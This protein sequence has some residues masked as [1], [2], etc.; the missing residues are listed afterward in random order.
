MS[1]QEYVRKIKAFALDIG[2]DLFGVADICDL[3]QEFRLEEKTRR[4][5]GLAISLGKRLNGAVLDDLVDRPTL[6]Y[7]HHYRQINAFLDRGALLVADFIE[8]NGFA[9]LAIAASQIVDWENQK[10]HLSHK[11]IGRAAGLGWIGR[12]NLLVHP[13]YG[14]RFRLVTVLTDMPL[15]SAAPLSSGCGSCR[16]CIASCPASAIKDEPEAFD[17]WACFEKLKGFR[18]QGLVPQFICGLCVRNCRGPSAGPDRDEVF[19]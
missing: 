15:E 13:D 10:A 5:F 1:D 19:R 18:K 9:A 11:H 2:F 16:A 8:R 6:L 3:R 12:N 17:H 7:F 14:S 4:R